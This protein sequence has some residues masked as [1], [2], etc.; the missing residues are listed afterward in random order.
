MYYAMRASAPSLHREST[1]SLIMY[2]VHHYSQETDDIY[3][4]L[5]VCP[6][7]PIQQYGLSYIHIRE[8]VDSLCRD[9][10]DARIM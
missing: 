1:D 8:S 6:H 7:R 9:G 5:E 10:A 4:Y 2:F 3:N